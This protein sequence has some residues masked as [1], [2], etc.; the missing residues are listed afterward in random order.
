MNTPTLLT[1]IETIV[2]E[3][4]TPAQEL[5]YLDILKNEMMQAGKNIPL[6]SADIKMLPKGKHITVAYPSKAM[7]RNYKRD[8]K[9]K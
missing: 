9:K 6:D 3:M 8:F 5:S 2:P 1:E 4:E 7:I